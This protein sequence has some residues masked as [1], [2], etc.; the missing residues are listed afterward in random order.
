[1]MLH[2][3]RGSERLESLPPGQPL[4]ITVPGPEWEASHWSA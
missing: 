1:L 3:E 4:R 2:F